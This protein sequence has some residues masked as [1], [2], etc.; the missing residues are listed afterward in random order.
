MLFVRMK[1]QTASGNP[2]MQRYSL[3]SAVKEPCIDFD[4]AVCDSNALLMYE[5][6]FW[7]VQFANLARVISPPELV[8]EIK[9]ELKKATALYDMN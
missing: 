7:A 1:L 9:E 8:E 6:S 4:N 5:T 3:K 2:P